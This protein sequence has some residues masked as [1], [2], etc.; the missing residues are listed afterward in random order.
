MTKDGFMNNFTK[1]V[2]AFVTLMFF[3]TGCGVKEGAEF[4][5][6]QKQDN[7]LAN[8]VSNLQVQVNELI[9]ENNGLRTELATN[10]QAVGLLIQDERQQ[11]LNF[12]KLQK[13][14]SK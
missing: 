10:S 4:Y 13:Q 3:L 14:V 7:R 8:A 5:S 11:E 2:F 12:E 1:A 9:I 6:L